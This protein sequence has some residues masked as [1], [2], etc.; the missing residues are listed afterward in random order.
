MKL[1]ITRVYTVIITTSGTYGNST[2]EREREK[3]LFIGWL[4]LMAYQPL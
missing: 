1:L 3:G 4:V 2:E